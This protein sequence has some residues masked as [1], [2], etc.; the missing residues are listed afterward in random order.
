MSE[1]R[2]LKPHIVTALKLMAISTAVV[3]LTVCVNY[4]TKDRIAA[5]VQKKTDTAIAELFPEGDI[6]TLSFQLTEK[7]KA[8]VT[9]IYSVKNDG[10]ITGYCIALKN[11][12]YGGEISLIVGITSGSKI[13]GVKVISHTETP[14]IGAPVLTGGDLLAGFNGIY[15]TS[16]SSVDTVSGATFTSEAVRDA[17][18]IAA[19]LA[20][21]I[22]SENG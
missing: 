9:E 4:V 13:S 14:S 12:G 18:Q 19:D 17:V 22:I 10:Y 2:S 11:N 15:T 7:E 1:K 21:R 20:E 6:G 16:V 5:N 8:H 3:L